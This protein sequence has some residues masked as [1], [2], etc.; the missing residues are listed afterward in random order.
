MIKYDLKCGKGHG[1]EAWFR[2]SSS[3]DAQSAAGELAC[4]LCGSKEVEKE[5]MAPRIGKGQSEKR[6][7]AAQGPA[8]AMVALR[9]MRDYVEKNFD[10]VGEQF[11]EEARRIHYGE[12]EAHDIYGQASDE[13]AE[14]LREEGVAFQ[15]LPFPLQKEN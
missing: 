2:N 10:N 8:E 9:K 11:P 3:F 1:F 6:A 14:A 15:K 7:V 12:T 13:E 4:P 5:L